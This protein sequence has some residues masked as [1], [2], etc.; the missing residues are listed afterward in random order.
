VGV[1]KTAAGRRSSDFA[2]F[3]DRYLDLVA[4]SFFLGGGLV[5]NVLK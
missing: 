5:G 3:R 2:Q 1:G 4:E